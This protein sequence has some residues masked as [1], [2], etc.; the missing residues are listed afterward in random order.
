MPDTTRATATLIA[1]AQERHGELVK[2][3]LQTGSITRAAEMT[4]Y[5]R[6]YASTQLNSAAFLAAVQA[7]QLETGITPM[8][9]AKVLDDAL[10]AE[11][12]QLA[13][14]GRGGVREIAAPDHRTRL[15]AVGMVMKPHERQAAAHAQAQARAERPDLDALAK[16][17]DDELLDAL[18]RRG[19]RQAPPIEVDGRVD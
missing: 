9:L 19:R 10:S 18:A 13:P 4:G 8:R 1:A 6:G 17:S 3:Y 5:S 16:L 14:D 15:S 12:I 2:A 7:A 11:R